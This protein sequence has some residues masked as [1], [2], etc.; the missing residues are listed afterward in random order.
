M[1]YECSGR[2]YYFFRITLI[3]MEVRRFLAFFKP[4]NPA[5]DQA[6]VPMSITVDEV[7]SPGDDVPENIAR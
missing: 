5:S 2:Y 7:P 1:D 6:T 3:K 4:S